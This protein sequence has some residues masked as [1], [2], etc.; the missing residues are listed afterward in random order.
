MSEDG[1]KI[2]FMSFEIENIPPGW[3]ARETY[4]IVDDNEYI[5][6]V[7]LAAPGK[8]FT[9]YSKATMKRKRPRYQG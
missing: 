6:T 7:E 1:K 2:V 5:E 8:E 3:R 4:E 9:V